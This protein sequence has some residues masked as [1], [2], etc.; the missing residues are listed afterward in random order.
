MLKR[1]KV[2]G[3]DIIQIYCSKIQPVLEYA[4]PC[5]HPGLTIEQTDDIEAIQRRAARFVNNNYDYRASV[6]DMINNLNWESLEIRRQKARLSMLYKIQNNLVEIAPPPFLHA[7]QR[8]RPGYP[9]QLQVVYVSTES[10]KNS[11][12][13]RTIRQW[14]SLH[15]SIGTLCSY[16]AFQTALSSYSP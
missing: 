12:F 9:H 4:S 14:N 16:G 13:I 1:A 10:Y 7:P 6:T 2:S 11:F 15:P 8:P 5:W 3:K